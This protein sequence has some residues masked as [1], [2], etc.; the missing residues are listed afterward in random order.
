MNEEGKHIKRRT[1]RAPKTTITKEEN[2]IHIDV[3][4]LPTH[5]T[6]RNEPNER[7]LT[8]TEQHRMRKERRIA[9]RTQ[10]W[11]RKKTSNEK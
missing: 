6:E 1:T 8:E 5:K 9:D 4:N 3:K 7:Q 2:I 11:E 10:E